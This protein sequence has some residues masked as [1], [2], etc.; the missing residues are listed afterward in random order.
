M[1]PY[2]PNQPFLPTAFEPSQLDQRGFNPNIV[3]NGMLQLFTEIS[4]STANIQKPHQPSS[5]LT[6][7]NPS[8]ESM[9]V[10]D[11]SPG[12]GW[13][14]VFLVVVEQ[15]LHKVISEIQLR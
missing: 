1:L 3:D 5:S 2:P 9:L 14:F 7:D 12:V 15:L 10:V 6:F 4:P 8:N 11:H 13:L